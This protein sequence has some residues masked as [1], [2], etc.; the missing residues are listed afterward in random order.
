MSLRLS[1][2]KRYAKYEVI[3]EFKVTSQRDV[4]VKIYFYPRETRFIGNDGNTYGTLF[5]SF[6]GTTDQQIGGGTQVYPGI[7]MPLR[8]NFQCG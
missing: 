8:I 3:A 5:L 2:L 1:L 6:S 7:S 4:P